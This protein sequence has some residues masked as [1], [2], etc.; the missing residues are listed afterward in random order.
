MALVVKNVPTNAGD[1]R[2]VGSIARSRRFPREGHGNPLH[3]SCLENPTDS[4]A[5]QA[6]VHGAPKSW[7]QL[8]W[9]HACRV[10][11]IFLQNWEGRRTGRR[12]S[13]L[14]THQRDWCWSW[15][16]HTL[17]T[18]CRELTYRKRPW[19]WERLRAEGEE[20]E[21]GW[22]GWMASPTQWPWTLANSRRQWG[23]GKPAALQS[24][25]LWRI[26]HDLATEQQ[27][28]P[29][30]CWISCSESS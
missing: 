25:G 18:W 26:R 6:T 3:Y 19:C 21:R 7:T 4:G 27:V 9:Q 30:T 1:V 13:T 29:Q 11:K 28:E 20:G 5:W 15:R 14:N 8:K 16:S 2:D 23:T 12:K 24:T 22:D 17:A 10:K